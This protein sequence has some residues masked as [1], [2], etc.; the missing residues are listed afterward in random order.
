MN[1]LDAQTS[2]KG[3]ETTTKSSPKN[4]F[5]NFS[6]HLSGSNPNP[7]NS[8]WDDDDSGDFRARS[9]LDDK[10]W[11]DAVKR[12][13][14]DTEKR[15]EEVEDAE[16]DVDE[17]AEDNDEGMDDQEQADSYRLWVSCCHWNF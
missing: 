13:K 11:Q 6:E 17:Q 8:L 14:V 12:D 9:S 7:G 4:T 15:R 16:D 5:E 2:P 10:W 3:A 1:R